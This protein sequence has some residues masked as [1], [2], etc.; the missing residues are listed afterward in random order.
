MYILY[1]VHRGD[2]WRTF[3]DIK[4]ICKD[5]QKS[6][7]HKIIF[8]EAGINKK[9]EETKHLQIRFVEDL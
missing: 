4:Y 9:S 3:L 7:W 1:D 8:L 2:M 5:L 6:N